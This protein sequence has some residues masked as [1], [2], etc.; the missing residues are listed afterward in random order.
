M[1]S[2]NVACLVLSCQTE[3]HGGPVFNVAWCCQPHWM[4][5]RQHPTLKMD[6]DGWID[7]ACT[8]S[9]NDWHFAGDIFKFIFLSENCCILIE[10]SLNSILG[11][12]I[13]N[14]SALVQVMACHRIVKYRF[15]H[16]KNIH[17]VNLPKIL[18]IFTMIFIESNRQVMFI[19]PGS[20]YHAQDIKHCNIS[21]SISQCKHVP[22]GSLISL[23]EY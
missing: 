22:V 11:G 9:F 15:Q 5:Q 17:V 21:A 18:K 23:T 2:E 8:K 14:K 12:P 7:E 13:D 20:G 6:M 3:M 1:M 19:R 10:I 16:Q 4:G